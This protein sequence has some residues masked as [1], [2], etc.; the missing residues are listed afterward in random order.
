MYEQVY[1][2]RLENSGPSTS[3]RSSASNSLEFQQVKHGFNVL[4][5][6]LNQHARPIVIKCLRFRKV[7]SSHGQRMTSIETLY[8]VQQVATPCQ[9]AVGEA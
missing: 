8:S 4:G 3:V 5:V 6:T 9:G 1:T 2:L 7:S